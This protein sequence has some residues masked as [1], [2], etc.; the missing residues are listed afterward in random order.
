MIKLLMPILFLVFA[1]GQERVHRKNMQVMMKW[2]LTEYLDLDE[3]QAE[4]F[5]PKMNT[6]EKKIKE[7]NGKIKILKDELE[8]NIES[9]NSSKKINRINIE[10]IKK[11]E[12]GKIEL[13]SSYLLSLENVLEPNQVSKLMVFE[14]KFKRTLKDQIRKHPNARDIRSRDKEKSYPKGR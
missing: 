2:Q 13:K 7:I 3:S 4:K 9:G 14:K 5:F 6:H 10:K 12:Q 11:L 8:R 1:F